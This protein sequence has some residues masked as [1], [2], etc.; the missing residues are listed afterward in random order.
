[1]IE[2]YVITLLIALA[3]VPCVIGG[4]VAWLTRPRKYYYR[5]DGYRWKRKR[6]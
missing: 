5:H 3:S 6:Y 2:D 4:I 1:M